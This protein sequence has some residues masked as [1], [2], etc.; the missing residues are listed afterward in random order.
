MVCLEA[1]WTAGARPPDPIPAVLRHGKDGPWH[2]QPNPRGICTEE[3]CEAA[4]TKHKEQQFFELIAFAA[5]VNPM[6]QNLQ[7]GEKFR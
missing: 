3:T 5:V 6:L 2:F 4:P 7:L 1:S